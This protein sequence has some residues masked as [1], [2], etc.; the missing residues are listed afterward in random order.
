MPVSVHRD[1]V[2]DVAAGRLDERVP[3]RPERRAALDAFEHDAVEVALERLAGHRDAAFDQVPARLERIGP[4]TRRGI[5]AYLK[6]DPARFLHAALSATWVHATLDSPP[7]ATPQNPSP[8]YVQGQ[9]LPYVPPLV[10][11]TDLGCG[12]TIGPI[13]AAHETRSV[14]VPR[15]SSSR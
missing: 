14:T 9:S 4:T 10:V 5:V 12:S 1:D 13:T 2:E 7:I 6:A 11:R 3:Q 15:R 8:E